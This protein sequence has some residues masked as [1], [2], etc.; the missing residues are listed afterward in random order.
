M[1]EVR[2]FDQTGQVSPLFIL[3]RETAAS[4]E[5]GTTVRSEAGH[6]SDVS[7][8]RTRAV[9]RVGRGARLAKAELCDNDPSVC[10]LNASSSRL[11]HGRP[12]G[13]PPPYCPLP[14]PLSHQQYQEFLP[15]PLANTRGPFLLRISV[16]FSLSPF[17]VPR[18]S[19][20]SLNPQTRNPVLVFH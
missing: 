19:F 12:N 16:P 11:E 7:E 20:E 2:V 6:R 4:D 9:E 14:L 3:A 13:R 15:P 8:M 18:L 5:T 17:L 10:A 1:G